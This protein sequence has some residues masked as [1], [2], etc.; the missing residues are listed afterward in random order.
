MTTC[1]EKSGLSAHGSQKSF[2]SHPLRTNYNYSHGRIISSTPKIGSSGNLFIFVFRLRIV[3][4]LK[5]EPRSCRAFNNKRHLSKPF[6]RRPAAASDGFSP[7][8]TH[9]KLIR[10]VSHPEQRF[11]LFYDSVKF[12]MKFSSS[13]FAGIAAWSSTW[14]NK[15]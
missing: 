6:F 3:S 12:I 5:K 2:L 10:S 9:W 8:H 13:T 14:L 1:R 11:P 15:I 4:Q 7:A